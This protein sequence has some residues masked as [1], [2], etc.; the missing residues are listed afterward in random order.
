MD[1]VEQR[2]VGALLEKERTVP[3]SYPMTLKGLQ[4]ACNQSSSR[5]PVVDYDEATIA[6]AIDRLKARGLARMVHA[7]HGSRVVKYRQVLDERLD[8]PAGDLALLTVLLLRGPHS[9]GELKT[10]TERL[11]GFADRSDVDAR[12][13][14]LAA[15]E[16]PLVGDLARQ[17]GQHDTRWVHLLGPVAERTAPA[18]VPAST[19]LPPGEVT[20]VV[21]ADGP[22]AR[23]ERVRTT[24]DTVAAAYAEQFDGEL[25]AKPLDR[26]LLERLVALADGGPLADAGCGPGHLTLHLAAAGAEV[27]GFDLSPAMVAEARRRYPELRFEVA[28]L[29]ALPTAP[30]GGGSAGRGSVD[31]GSRASSDDGDSGGGSGGGGWA[32]IAAWYSLVHLAASELRP[33]LALLTASLRPGG[34]LAFALHLGDE[35]RAMTE[36]LGHDV[37]VTF[38]LHH[39]DRVLD[40]VATAGLVDVEWYHRGPYVGAEVETER[41]YVLARRPPE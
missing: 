27:T 2:V 36:L 25:D 11:H 31:L 34:W 35:A 8:L 20:E 4:T 33:A 37:D 30:G 29:T 40:A 3:A 15:A 13:A 9:A 17:P 24:Y 10:R 12:L 5:D 7:S 28:D 32:A 18:P 39:R 21:L 38:T 22:L 26:W 19:G 41:L 23:D 14:E 6:A 16:P 1:E